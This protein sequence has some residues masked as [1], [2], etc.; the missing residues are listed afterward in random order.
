MY[1][2]VCA[3][4]VNMVI[5]S[6]NIL[7]SLVPNKKL[8]GM[9]FNRRR[10]RANDIIDIIKEKRLQVDFDNYKV[11]DEKRNVKYIKKKAKELKELM[12]EKEVQES[13]IQK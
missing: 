11:I 10:K 2:E 3:F 5:L 1:L 8:D 7:L 4:F 9:L 6:M 13:G 12:I